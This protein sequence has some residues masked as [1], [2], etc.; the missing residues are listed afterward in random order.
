M[1][2]RLTAERAAPALPAL[3]ALCLALSRCVSFACLL[4]RLPWLLALLSSLALLIARCILSVRPA[5]LT[6]SLLTPPLL[7][8]RLSGPIT[9][10]T[11]LRF[12]LRALVALRLA[13]LGVVSCVRGAALRRLF[14]IGLGRLRTRFFAVRS[15]LTGLLTALLLRTTRRLRSGIR[16]FALIRVRP[17]EFPIDLIRQVLQ[18]A[19]CPSQG[20]GLVAEHAL[21]GLFDP[22]AKLTQPLARVP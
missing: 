1:L 9:C 12:L 6:L 8:F 7:S 17:P 11:G 3:P 13:S 16:R 2:A 20:F 5:A 10:R 19:L 21:C 18:L 4:T 22:F 15:A 14:G